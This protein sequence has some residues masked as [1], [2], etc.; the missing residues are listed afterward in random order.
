MI[1]RVNPSQID[2]AAERH[3]DRMLDSWLGPDMCCFN[4]RYFD[5]KTGLCEADFDD[6][7]VLTEV[8]DRHEFPWDDEDDFLHI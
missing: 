5:R 7:L 1:R 4:C 6:E 3:F 2:A 8:C